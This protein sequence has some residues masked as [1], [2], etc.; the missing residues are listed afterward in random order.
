MRKPLTIAVS[1]CAL[2]LLACGPAGD[3]DSPNRTPLAEKWFTRAQASY[4]TGDFEDAAQAAQSALEASPTDTEIR[5][6]AARLSL[7]RLDFGKAAKLT[8][9][10]TKPDA[11]AIRG[12]AHWYAGNVEAA[13]D[14]LE[15]LLRDP[16]VKDPWARQ[17][18]TLARS[19]GT[20]RKPF[21]VDGAMVAAVEMPEAG[22]A[23]VV[24]CEL[25]GE[26]ILALVATA[27]SEVVIDSASRK[28]PAWVTLKF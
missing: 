14:A 22:P 6:L 4:K 20:N 19:G 25:N 11:L 15:G 3:A 27:T 24:P 1:S 12:R 5:L 18:A 16:A 10:L 17:I 23:M 13:A 26:H 21:H 2:S 7:A 28:E 8:E 9:G